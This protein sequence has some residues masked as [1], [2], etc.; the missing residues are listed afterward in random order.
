LDTGKGAAAAGK[1]D[2]AQGR[3]EAVAKCGKFLTENPNVPLVLQ[4][5]GTALGRMASDEMGKLK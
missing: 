5:V 3:F 1:R 4:M 2:D